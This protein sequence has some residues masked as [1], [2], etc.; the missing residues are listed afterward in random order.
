MIEPR[1]DAEESNDAHAGTA[2][3]CLIGWREELLLPEA[4]TDAEHEPGT[5][6]RAI[7]EGRLRAIV[8]ES[9]G[10]PG[11]SWP[12]VHA[13]LIAAAAAVAA[14]VPTRAGCRFRSVAGVRAML[15]DHEELLGLALENVAGASEFRIIVR[16]PEA[17]RAGPRTR[18]PSGASWWPM[19]T[20]RPSSP[21]RM[22]RPTTWRRSGSNWSVRAPASP[23]ASYRG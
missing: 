6:I 7:D 5:R 20:G 10:E 14:V 11:A 3:L 8:L 9:D 23:R 16:C 2:W 17:T 4:L 22:R 15:R 18:W 1:C 12:A 21:Q 13:G 19:R